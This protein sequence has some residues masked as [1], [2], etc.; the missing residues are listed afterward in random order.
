MAVSAGTSRHQGG[1]ILYSPE[2]TVNEA[3][4]FKAFQAEIDKRTIEDEVNGALWGIWRL[5]FLQRRRMDA[6]RGSIVC[7][8]FSIPLLLL[9]LVFVFAEA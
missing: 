9:L 7:F 4:D 2:G 3:K 6:L 1:V 8:S 5:S